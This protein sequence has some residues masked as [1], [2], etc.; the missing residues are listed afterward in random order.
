MRIPLAIALC[1]TFLAGCSK[2]PVDSGIEAANAV[3]LYVMSNL[4]EKN[5]SYQTEGLIRNLQQ[6]PDCQQYIDALRQAG[7]GSP[8]EGATEYRIAHV[9]QDAQ[10]AA[11][12]RPD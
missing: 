3:S 2:S 9:Y 11:C 6:R 10:H 5:A 7:R 8:Y 12:E 4:V 1:C